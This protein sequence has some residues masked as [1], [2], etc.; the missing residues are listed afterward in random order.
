MIK[1]VSGLVNNKPPV[2]TVEKIIVALLVIIGVLYLLSRCGV[3]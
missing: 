2:M 1:K 3:L